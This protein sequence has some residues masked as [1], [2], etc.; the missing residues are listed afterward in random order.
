MPSRL[1]VCWLDL[2][3]FTILFALHCS[4]TLIFHC[5]TPLLSF[6]S[7]VGLSHS[8]LAGFCVSLGPS[9]PK[10][11]KEFMTLDRRSL[12]WARLYSSNVTTRHTKNWRQ[13]RFLRGCNL[14][15]RLFTILCNPL[16]H[17]NLEIKVI[18]NKKITTQNLSLACTDCH[19]QNNEAIVQYSRAVGGKFLLWD[20]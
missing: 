14:K 12:V 15:H 8:Q 10:R 16:M 19:P 13:L 7:Y 3:H 18:I 1:L 11:F 6:V 2:E 5:C 4:T 17:M 20:V 9:S